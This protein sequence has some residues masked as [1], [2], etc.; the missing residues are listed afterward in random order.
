MPN[1]VPDLRFGP[2]TSGGFTPAGVAA[3]DNL[4]P[5]AVVRELI[6]NALDAARAAAAAPAVVR[7]RVTRT[8]R[9]T[10]PGIESYESAFAKAV[11]TQ[12][13]MTGGALTGQAQLVAETIR[14]ALEREYLDVLSVLDNGIGLNEQRMNALLSDGVS[15][16]G[17]GATGTY[18]NGHSTA[19]PAS[20]LRYVLYGGLT[21]DGHRIGAGHA[22]LASHLKE[23][24]QHLRTGDGF[25][26][27]N[28][29]AGH[30]T[31]YDYATGRQLPALIAQALDWIKAETTHGTAVIIPAFNDFLE[32]DQ[33]LWDMV[34]HA[35]SA[36]FFAAIEEGELVVMVEDQREE[37]E[38]E[39]KVLDK[40]TLARVLDTHRDK[41]RAAAF[42][43]GRRAFEAHQA[44]RSGERHLIDTEAGQIEIR[45]LQHRDGI[46]RIHLCRNGMWITDKIPGFYQRFA[47]QIPFHAVLSLNARDG[48]E[49]HDF[50]RIA[51]GPLHDAINIKRLPAPKRTACRN[52]FREIAEW[53]VSKIP[54]VKSDAYMSDD[55]LTLD[56][57]DGDG[58]GRGKSRN[59]FW[60]MPVPISRSPARQLHLFS[61]TSES[62]GEEP[63]DPNQEGKE[64]SPP[65]RNRHRRRPALP[66]FFQAASRPAG[67]NRRH[68]L[69]ECDKSCDD[70]ELRL[71]V[72]EALDATCERP[73]QDTYTPAVL[74]N[75]T[76]N[77][78][79][80]SDKDFIRWD[81]EIIGVRLGDL[82]E[83][84]SVEV[85]TDYRLAG[86]F[87]DLPNPSLRVEVFKTDQSRGADAEE[88]QGS[89]GEP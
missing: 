38:A 17:E 23:G 85:E 36:N 43:N 31:L 32:E 7:F 20:D 69:I 30:G 80:A 82:A 72:D 37:R 52:A 18:G 48:P 60:G 67:R 28:F 9:D 26:I 12:V 74:G 2:G 78:E 24:E 76:I 25:Y 1:H 11:S 65:N 5:A 61:I 71:V 42:L 81:D 35:A 13:T 47:D 40:S 66:T 79:P 39:T 62:V 41:R 89:E 75:I 58:R 56:F 21:D 59:V 64:S 73:G 83:R 57:G 15:V 22:V 10:I 49:L 63:S 27:R 68:I 6:Q 87:S 86:D 50:I 19:I 33:S 34:S 14:N 3:F 29:R 55:Y 45:F 46:T 88:H 8:R 4:R 16:K 70:A 84:A 44:Y 53:I 77:G 54:T 51:E